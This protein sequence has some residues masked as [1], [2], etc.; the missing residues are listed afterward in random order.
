MRQL[1]TMLKHD[2]KEVKLIMASEGAE[3][4]SL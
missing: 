4:V 3:I 2:I 1:K